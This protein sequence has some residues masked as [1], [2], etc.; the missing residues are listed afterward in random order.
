MHPKMAVM[1]YAKFESEKRDFIKSA[2]PVT[3]PTAVVKQ[4]R[5]TRILKKRFPVFPRV[6]LAIPESNAVL[7]ISSSN[8]PCTKAPE[9]MSP[10]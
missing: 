6:I 5:L 9:R 4:A 7:E 2:V 1:R 10:A 8:E 3:I